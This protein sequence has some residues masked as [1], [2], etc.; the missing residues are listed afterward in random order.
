MST[1]KPIQSQTARAPHQ[2]RCTTATASSTCGF[3]LH[4]SLG[5]S[6]F[7]ATSTSTDTALATTSL[8]INQARSLVEGDVGSTLG[9]NRYAV[10]NSAWHTFS[11]YTYPWGLPVLLAPVMA[12]NG[13]VDWT[14]GIDYA[15][16]KLVVNITLGIALDG[17]L[18]RVARKRIH[19]ARRALLP[20][21]FATNFWY[22]THT[23]QV[24]SEFPFLMWLMLFFLGP[25]GFANA[26]RSTETGVLRSWCSG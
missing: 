3:G 5:C 19:C 9:D 26:T 22:V 24:L 20:L 11:P 15:P 1:T 17:V 13:G 16:L 12:V 8:Y 6:S 25:T 10:D 7:G 18:R 14:T 21:F 23:D 2:N 4:C